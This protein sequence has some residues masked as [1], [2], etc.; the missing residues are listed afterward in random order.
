MQ[1]FITHDLQEPLALPMNYQHILQAIIYKNLENTFG[2]SNYMH[3]KGFQYGQRQFRLFTFSLL[4]GRYEIS[5]GRICF[6]EKIWWEIRSPEVFLIQMLAEKIKMNG[7]WYGSN[8]Y[9]HVEVQLFDETIEW[10][11]V[12]VRMITP[13]CVYSTDAET[14]KTHFYAPDEQEFYN[15]INDNFRHKYEAYYGVEPESG[16]WMN[17]TSVSE[18]DRVVTKYKGFYISGWR[19]GYYLQGERKYLDFLYQMGLGSKNAQGFGM[20][21]VDNEKQSDL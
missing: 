1:L 19:G 9:E 6:L 8:H 14:K 2:F 15:L 11:A 17:P 16:I 12:P 21:M 13:I 7:I 18:R 20:F 5:R 3:D 4:N 10:D